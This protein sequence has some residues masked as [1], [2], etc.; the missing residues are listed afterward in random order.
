MNMFNLKNSWYIQIKKFTQSEFSNV[1]CNLK[2]LEYIQTERENKIM[3]K[4]VCKVC[5]YV[6]V[7][8]EAPKACPI[9]K[10]PAEKF[11]ELKE[12]GED[13]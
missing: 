1:K 8:E 9:C 7:G 6:H 5:G 4:Y 11:E 10:V 12:E 3:K 2:L 13:A